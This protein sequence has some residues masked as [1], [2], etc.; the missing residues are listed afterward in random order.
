MNIEMMKN[1]FI[2]KAVMLGMYYKGSSNK[3]TP[4][5]DAFDSLMLLN[6]NDIHSAK[7]YKK[8]KALAFNASENKG[9]TASRDTSRYVLMNLD[10]GEVLSDDD[11][12]S[13]SG[14]NQEQIFE[15]RK[16]D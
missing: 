15:Q 16:V 9:L 7:K 13:S 12:N 14:G 10:T 5:K 4:L 2:N 1:Q 3:D 8:R 11:Y 6:D